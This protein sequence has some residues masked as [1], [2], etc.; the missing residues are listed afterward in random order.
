M[1]LLLV[2]LVEAR[3][4]HVHQSSVYSVYCYRSVVPVGMCSLDYFYLLLVEYDLQ[5]RT[6]FAGATVGPFTVGARLDLSTNFLS[7]SEF[8]QHWWPDCP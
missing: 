8:L 7:V 5:L 3:Y 4:A 6:I 1:I 2:V